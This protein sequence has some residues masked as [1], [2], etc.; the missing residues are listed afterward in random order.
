[1]VIHYS[2]MSNSNFSLYHL[3]VYCEILAYIHAYFYIYSSKGFTV[4]LIKIIIQY[5]NVFRR[6]M[7]CS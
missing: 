6:I 4:P 2:L 1:M 7:F 3:K 5:F